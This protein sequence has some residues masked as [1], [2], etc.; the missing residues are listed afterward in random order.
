MIVQ[1]VEMLY[2][3]T[4]RFGILKFAL[5]TINA[6]IGYLKLCLIN[7]LELKG[8][9]NGGKDTCQGDSG[10]SIFTKY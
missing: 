6:L 3:K 7:K 1:L 5:V 9:V 8:D 4:K 10:G 2:Q